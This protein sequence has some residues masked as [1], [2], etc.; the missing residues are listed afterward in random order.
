MHCLCKIEPTIC[1]AAKQ[2]HQCTP[3]S[4][5]GKSM[6]EKCGSCVYIHRLLIWDA[7]KDQ[8]RLFDVV[9]I[10]TDRDLQSEALWYTG[11][12]SKCYR[13]PVMLDKS[14]LHKIGS[15]F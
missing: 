15:P 11:I 2:A 3:S 5:Q 4:G 1:T 14:S 13:I 9:P 10:S 7:Q 8:G 12:F 6:C